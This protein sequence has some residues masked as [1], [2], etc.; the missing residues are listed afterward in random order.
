VAQL[1]RARPGF[2]SGRRCVARRP[3][4]GAAKRCTRFVRAGRATRR[5][6]VVGAGRL[7]IRRPRARGRY[8]IA[9]YALDAAGNRSATQRR[10]LTVR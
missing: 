4:R 3:R 10:A 1:E 8:R 7:A 9:V 2:R 5:A 6:A